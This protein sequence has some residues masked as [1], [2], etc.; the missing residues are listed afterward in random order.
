ME[1]M[2]NRECVSLGAHYFMVG[3]K[4]RTEPEGERAAEQMVPGKLDISGLR[5]DGACA[6]SFVVA[7][8][9]S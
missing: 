1:F 6:R 2:L 5:D 4:C 7:F 3:P 9:F 8:N